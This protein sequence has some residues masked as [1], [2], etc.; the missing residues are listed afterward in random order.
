MGKKFVDL[1]MARDCGCFAGGSVD[2]DTVTAAFTQ[3]LD[4]VTFEVTDQIDPLHEIE[5]R[6]SRITVLLRS[7][8]STSARLDSKT[9]WTAS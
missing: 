9:S 4:T 6:G 2:V 1:S 5:A 8:S 3:K 7:V